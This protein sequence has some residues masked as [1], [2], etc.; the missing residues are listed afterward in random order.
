MVKLAMK[1]RQVQSQMSKIKAAGQHDT[2]TLMVQAPDS[3]IV[4]RDINIEEL[5][6]KYPQIP[7]DLLKKVA[8]KI[9]DDFIGALQN[10]SKE[11]QK[12]LS[13]SEDII[14]Q[15]KTMMGNT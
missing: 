4:E 9:A 7:K 13:E 8:D 1:A 14:D 5:G 11:M 12:K 6:K 3:K 10:A 15:M 2:V